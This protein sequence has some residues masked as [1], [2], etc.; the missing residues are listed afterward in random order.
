M[1]ADQQGWAIDTRV[2]ADAKKAALANLLE[3]ENGPALL[4]TA[5]HG[6]SYGLKAI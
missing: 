1:G 6:M 3:D 2:G 4:F 5:S